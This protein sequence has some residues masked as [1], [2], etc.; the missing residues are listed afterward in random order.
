MRDD[1]HGLPVDPLEIFSYCLATIALSTLMMT[2]ILLKL[3]DEADAGV[4]VMLA[5]A[6]PL[7]TALL[8]GAGRGRGDFIGHLA[9]R[10]SGKGALLAVGIGT[11]IP[12]L[13]LLAPF[14]F[15][16]WRL[17]SWQEVLPWHPLML[18]VF[19]AGAVAVVIPEVG[20]WGWPASRT[21]SWGF[22]P[23]ALLMGLSYGLWKLPIVAATSLSPV[24]PTRLLLNIGDA[25]FVVPLL[26]ALRRRF[27][28]VWPAVLVVIT[29]RLFSEV[30]V[31]RFPDPLLLAPWWPVVSW[32]FYLLFAWLVASGA[33]RIP[34]APTERT[35]R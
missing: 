22:W 26:L 30:I 2:P 11:L 9:L 3:I 8:M 35:A 6:S 10:W 21:A 27:H 13:D 24:D 17:S 7:L 29:L 32:A 34:H 5:Y 19:G 15:T 12:A 4:L 23:V 28:S 1:G 33:P 20:W 31:I 18:L 25:V 14:L 16:S